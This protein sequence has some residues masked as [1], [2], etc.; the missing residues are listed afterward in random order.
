LP[1]FWFG[2][3]AI[4]VFSQQLRWLPAGG[5]QTLGSSGSVL[6]NLKHLILPMLV[7]ALVLVAQWSRYTRSAMLEV[8]HQDY[9]RTAR[10]KGLAQ[11]A[12]LLGH[13][14]RNALL[15]L[16]TLAGLQLPALFGGALVT[17]TVFSWPGM[18]LLFVTSLSMR[19]YPVLMAILMMTAVLVIIG[20]FL[21]DL[22]ATVVDPRI[23]LHT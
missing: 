12:A 20:N 21:A 2:L 6:D 13:G 3:I 16:V 10:A 7:L 22:A 11:R 15:P 8:L 14:F 17:E 23:R 5:M 9:M 19:D 1:T 4:F 18:G